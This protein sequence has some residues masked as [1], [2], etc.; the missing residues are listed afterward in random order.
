[1][2][3]HQQAVLIRHDLF[4]L[5]N[6]PFIHPPVKPWLD[7]HR[8]KLLHDLNAFLQ[9]RGFAAIAGKC[10]TGKTAIAKYL[11]DQLHQPSHQIVYVPL[12][13]L[14][15]NDLLRLICTRF[16]IESLYGRSKMIGAIQ[17]RIHEIQPVNPVIIFDEMQNASVK[18][19]DLIRMLANDHFDPTNTLS[20]LLIGTSEFFDKLR[21]AINES[22]QQRITYFQI[23]EEID[24]N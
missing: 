21:L 4:G 15:E 5:T 12:Y 13:H 14:S 16:N 8:K 6:T 24:E 2:H 17:Q 9:N 11:V 20:C 3:Y 18:S 1:M 7:D 22:L 10:G 23:L 19:M